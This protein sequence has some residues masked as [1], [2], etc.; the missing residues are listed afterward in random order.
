MQKSAILVISFG[1]T[2]EEGRKA[3]VLPTVNRIRETYGAQYD[4]FEGFTSRIV[5]KRLKAR[6]ILVE[7][8]SEL[9]ERV[10]QE[11]Y[12]SGIVQSLHLV[13]GQECNKLKRNMQEIAAKFEGV[14]LSFGRPLLFYMG[15][16]GEVPDDFQIFLEASAKDYPL[17]EGEGLVYV[18]HGGLSPENAAYSTLQLKALQMEAHKNTRIVTLECYPTLEDMVLPWQFGAMP[19]K[20]HL[21]P[22]LFVAGDHVN[23]DLFGDEEDSVKQQLMDA[24]YE[25]VEHRVALGGKPFVQDLFLAHLED[26]IQHR[27]VF[28]YDKK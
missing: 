20:V 24:G 5:M 7:S 26:A 18:G 21:L 6:G 10:L 8:E 2:Y 3:T 16:E 15:Q 4:V 22:L 27:Y 23:N 28:K 12:T 17:P 1:T 11:G 19:K 13:G 14:E 9:L 25:V